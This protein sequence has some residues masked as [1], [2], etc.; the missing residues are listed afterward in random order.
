M[1]NFESL[2]AYYRFY[3]PAFHLHKSVSYFYNI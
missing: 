2:F 1:S 3:M